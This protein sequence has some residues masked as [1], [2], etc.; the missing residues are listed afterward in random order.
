[1]LPYHQLMR[2]VIPAL[3]AQQALAGKPLGSP[4]P[5]ATVIVPP[6]LVAI[7]PTASTSSSSAAPHS[8]SSKKKRDGS[9]SPGMAQH[10]DLIQREKASKS[11]A[12]AKKK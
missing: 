7:V 5:A 8:F 6:S 3:K 10:L 9:M 2:H 4:G 12:K 1:M 11:K